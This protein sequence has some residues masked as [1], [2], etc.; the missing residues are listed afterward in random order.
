MS[1]IVVSAVSRSS[2]ERAA[3]A[4]FMSSAAGTS[5]VARYTLSP[6]GGRRESS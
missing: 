4:F 5:N 3:F 2:S 6:S 1:K